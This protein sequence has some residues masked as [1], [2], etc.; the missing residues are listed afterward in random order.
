MNRI[1]WSTFYD[2]SASPNPFQ[3]GWAAPPLR[4]T[5]D[6]ALFT[7][8]YNAN[9]VALDLLQEFR[10]AD[11]VDILA[12]SVVNDLDSIGLF[13]EEGELRGRIDRRGAQ[14]GYEWPVSLGKASAVDS[15]G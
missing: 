8:R 5:L 9:D 13:D 14:D 15:R 11:T 6:S 1:G 4:L 10:F 3:A 12:S 2:A 7:N